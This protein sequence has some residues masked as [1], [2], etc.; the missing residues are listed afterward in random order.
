VTDTG[1]GISES[2]VQK[3]FKPFSQADSS[4]AREYG[5]TGLGLVLSRN[6]ARALGGSLDLLE[7]KQGVGSKF[8]VSL[9]TKNILAT[10]NT[11]AEKSRLIGTSFKGIEVLL[12]ED[13][14]DNQFLLSKILKQE[15][16][17]VDFANNGIEAITKAT[18]N[19]YDIILMDIQMPKMDG[20]KA[21]S[22]LRRSGYSKPIIALT[23]NALKGDKE[24]ALAA[25]F[26]DYITKPVQRTELF[27]S[28]EKFIRD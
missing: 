24:K 25:G 28:L 18:N 27:E 20:N 11:V 21:T 26:D 1:L 4:M 2:Q 5:G 23:A 7:S 15:G 13:Q 8:K 9:V 14:P 19:A 16:I 12:A 10:A 22:H 6:L 3:L 17:K